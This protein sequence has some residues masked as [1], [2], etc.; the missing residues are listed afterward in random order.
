MTSI[1]DGPTSGPTPTKKVSGDAADD[2]LKTALARMDM[3]IGA[4]SSSRDDELDDLK[5]FA[6]SPDNQFQWPQDVLGSRVAA[7][8]NTLGARP[9]LTINKLP[10]HVRQVTNDQRQ[11]RPAGKVIP[12][13][14][15]A[16]AD[17]AEV[18]NGMVRHIQYISNADVAYDTACENQVTFGEGYFRIVTAYAEDDSFDQDI[19]IKR[20]RNSFSVY[21]DPMI[22]DP[23]GE[24]AKWCFIT[25]DILKSEF[26]DLYP[27]ATPIGSI[28]TT[29]TGDSS[30]S[31]WFTEETLR[32]AEY[33]CIESTPATLNLYPDGS[34]AFDGDPEND[35][36]LK[37]YKKPVRSRESEKKQIM[38]YKINGYEILDQRKWLGKH[39]PVIRVLGNEFEIEGQLQ[40]SGIV[41]NAKD[42]Q[43][44]YNY[45]VSQEAEMLA[46]A[47]KAPFI[48]YGG[49]FEGFEQQWKTANTKNWPY[50]EVNPDVTDGNGG[51]LPLPQRSQPPMVQSGLI[52]AKNGAS[53]DIK[54]TTGQ[55]N[56]SLGM[57]SNE[58]SGKAILA[59]QHEG[60]VGTYHYVDN[61]A[62]AIRYATRQIVDLIPKVY[63]TQ[64][65]A[66]VLGEDG[67]S[68]MV[69]LDPTMPSPVT[70]VVDDAGNVIKKIYNPSV[71]RY[72]VCVATGPGYATKRQEA[73]DAMA[74]LLQGNPQLWAVAGDLFVKNMDWP[75]AQ[76][77]AARFKKT[78][79]PK[80]L[81]NDEPNPE[82][83]QAQQ[84]LQQTQQQLQQA[85][86]MLANIQNSME[87]KDVAIK[88]FEAQIKAFDAETKRI[89]ATAL[90]TQ[91]AVSDKNVMNETQIQD[92][93]MGV[94]HAAAMS[95]VVP[96]I[97]PMQDPSQAPQ[98]PQD[99]SQMMQPP[100]PA[101]P[102]Q[103]APQPMPG[104]NNAV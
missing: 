11:N 75:G 33:F 18:F 99:P 69:E 81:Q 12:A 36:L 78:I 92:I 60:D 34:T 66:H 65:I 28:P 42:A 29:G 91:A 97:P 6:G 35:E 13:D 27:N 83:Q 59:R 96:S 23:C 46:L 101:Q 73:L 87:A 52:A 98:P 84:Q 100:Q 39:I 76:E 2:I 61:L 88:M 104:G 74:N 85:H 37:Q 79:D 26:E 56:A 43:R 3:A 47:P 70:Q 15:D 67:T 54:E 95:G 8:G 1:V 30:P 31:S 53:D 57:E 20:V 90:A 93:A 62:R 5:F 64:R 14:S 55:Y 44:M 32:I 25:E 94:V 9:C 50:L 82:L 17:V 48:G 19:L 10:Q 68:S 49:Q 41:R 89:T 45:W 77:L 40:V 58:R 71:G 38:W 63:D 24:D 80:I 51:T 86:G 102:V 22:Q 7:A 4:L 16:D 72:D 21:M 103:Q